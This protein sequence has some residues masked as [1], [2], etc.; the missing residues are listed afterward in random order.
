MKKLIYLVIIVMM[1]SLSA[2]LGTVSV[3][4]DGQT[5]KWEEGSRDYFFMFK[6]LVTN[7][8]DEATTSASNPQADTCIDINTGS[9][10]TLTPTDIPEDAY[11]EA[12]YLT[13]MGGVDPTKI[14]D[15]TDH[16]VTLTFTNTAIPE[17]A[18]ST[19]VTAVR[20]GKNG[21]PAS[22]EFEMASGGSA[23]QAIFAY[24]ADVTNFFHKIHEL[25]S[26]HGVTLSGTSLLGNYNVKGMDC[27]A[28]SDYITTSGVIGAWGLV[29]VYTSEKISPKK[30]YIYNGL[31]AYRFQ[32]EDINVAGFQLPDEAVVRLSMMVGEGDPGLSAATD[33]SFQPATPETLALSGSSNPDWVQLTNDCNVPYGQDSSG[34]PFEFVEVF[35][36]I[37]SSYGWNSDAAVCIGGDPYNVDKTKIEYAIDV[38]TFLLDSK[39]PPFDAHLKKDD[40]NFWLKVSANQDQVYTNMIVLSVDTKKPKFDIPVNED[41]P[42]GREKNYCSCSTGADAICD[43]RPFYYTIKVQNWGENIANNITVQ[44]TLPSEVE[45]IPGTTEYSSTYS[46]SLKKGIKWDAIEDGA[47]D[48]FPLAQPYTIANTMSY[49]NGT[50]CPETILVRFKV[51]PKANLPKHAVIANTVK[52][53]EAGGGVYLSNSSVPIRLHFEDCPP[54]PDCPEPTKASCLG[55]NTTICETDK[56]CDDGW[57]CIDDVCVEPEGSGEEN[58]VTDSELSY[59]LGKGSPDSENTIMIATPSKDLILGRFS[60]YDTASSEGDFNFEN[61]SLSVQK[62]SEI[63]LTNIKLFY[64]KNSNGQLDAEEPEIASLDSVATQSIDLPIA[65]ASRA[66]KAN[67]MHNFIVQGDAEFV[68]RITTS[69]SMKINI[70]NASAIQASDKG[71]LTVANMGNILLSNWKFEPTQGF[72]VTVGEN[73]PA[74]PGP[75]DINATIPIMQLRVKSMEGGDTITGI[76][77]KT[78]QKSKQ[79]G[80]GVNQ[81]SLIL[82]NNGNGMFDAGEQ[83]LGRCE[84]TTATTICIISS[85]NISFTEAEAEKHLLFVAKLNLKNDETAQITVSENKVVLS[86]ISTPIYK[87]P[88]TSKLFTN[89]CVEG[90][91]SCDGSNGGGKII[92]DGCSILFVD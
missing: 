61:I 71:T 52:I 5:L 36:S 76:T 80:D 83:E 69:N 67:V 60:L 85:L 9:T 11:I 47:G 24:R 6:S 20:Q 89:T 82:D 44:D 43:D 91:T 48:T 35:N 72:I 65:M 30:I 90:D 66:F 73:D 53:S 27:S 4:H 1:Q 2:G 62:N 40:N 7:E 55:E 13:W 10:Y 70:N 74:V 57:K 23:G 26:E 79:F 84:F 33:A 19:P 63:V 16:E 8:R 88:V 42:S 64:D 58:L 75:R 21:D 12:A 54:K 59:S 29:I 15:P 46:W 32:S 25:G 56:D 14:N 37:S 34:Q 49:C 77:A 39:N 78:T 92:D 3:T 81:L 87:L 38:D 17:I 31:Q 68:G 22:F 28:A 18:Y 41:T 86:N 50:D 51:K 45:Y